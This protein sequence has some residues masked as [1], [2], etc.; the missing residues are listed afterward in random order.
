MGKARP[1]SASTGLSTADCPRHERVDVMG[2]R[3]SA[4]DMLTALD[5][6]DSWVAER[7]P[8]Y[9]CVTGVH[10]VMESQSDPELRRIHNDAGLVTPDGMPLVWLCRHHGNPQV[11][12]VYGPD[13]LLR[14]C[15]R[16]LESGWSHFFYGGADGV[17]ES[18]AE[19]LKLKF[20]G[21]KVAGCH[22]P[23]FRPLTAA[24]DAAIRGQI[25]D[26]G[27][28]IVWVGLSTPKQERWMAAN[29]GRLGAPVLIGV[30]AAFDFH[31]GRKRQAPLWMQ[32]SGLEW[33]FRLM[34]EP[35]RLG[36]RYLKNNPLFLYFLLARSLQRT[37]SKSITDES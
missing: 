14:C 22:C 20:P 33:L 19:R 3:V 7:T 32:H 5:T 4:I 6:I 21:L 24:E 30:G 36:P 27:A 12:R 29:V 31:S 37:A 23:P 28:D 35:R 34:Q 11:E 17:A 26:S 10:G 15:Q 2:I 16:S 25:R 18:L 9:V 13:L 1:L 8:N